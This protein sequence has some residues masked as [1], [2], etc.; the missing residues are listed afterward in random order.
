MDKSSSE[1]K[2]KNTDQSLQPNPENSWSESL[3][4]NEAFFRE[5]F[6]N[7]DTIVYRHFENQLNDDLQ[8]CAIFINGMVNNEIINENIILPIVNNIRLPEKE[9]LIDALKNQVIICNDIT[10][11]RE[12]DKLIQAILNGDTVLLVDGA[13]EALIINSKG[14]PTRF[15]T[16]PESEKGSLGP[17]EGFTESLLINLALVRRKLKTHE[18][19]F[20]FRVLGSRSHTKACICYL[21]GLAQEAILAELEK[22][23]D[24]INLDGILDTNYLVE[25]I[26]DA[27]FSPFKTIGNTERP[28]VVV[29]KLL[30]GRI[31]LILDGTPVAIT[32]PYLFN[33][34]FQTNDDY[35]TNFYFASIS[36]IIRIISFILTI[37]APAVFIA[38]TTFHQ[39]I[40]PSSLLLSISLARQ[41][42]PFPSIV[43]ALILGFIF[44]SIREAGVRATSNI[45]SSLSIVGALILGEAAVRANF[46]SA[47]MLIVV[48][49]TVVSGLMFPKLSGAFIILRLVLVFCAGLMG[50]YGYIF[51]MAG[52]LIHLF[53]IRSFGVPYMT[54]LNSIDFQDLKDTVIRAPW[55]YMEYRPK[56]I[57]AL[58]RIRQSNG[59]KKLE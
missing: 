39:E 20:K 45:G 52:L 12:F 14:W 7:D 5:L 36:R 23:L 17:R 16:E 6:K 22:R 32:L 41:R 51:A 57:G 13:L 44:E 30:E 28:D 34:Y 37:S 49:F 19:K 35:Y 1:N 56:F 8:F 27:P 3:A 10:K 46:F 9:N 55:W 26:K 33:E 43:E 50:I 31:A 24:Q 59:D 25:L 48:G 11:T 53:Q 38:L 42:V 29:G 47:P 2:S 21:E 58:N 15:I 4:Q 40:I 18:L 54:P